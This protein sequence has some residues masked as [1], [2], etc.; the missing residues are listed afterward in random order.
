MYKLFSIRLLAFILL[1]VAMA[2]HG[3]LSARKL[4]QASS[5]K[6]HSA[7]N[8][9][10]SSV[11]THPDPQNYRNHSAPGI[12]KQTSKRSLRSVETEA[13]R[14]S[15]HTLAYHVESQIGHQASCPFEWLENYEAR[16]IPRRIVEQV[17]RSCRSCG[18]SRQCVQLKVRTEVFFGDTGEYGHQFVRAGCA[19]MPYE[20][21]STA[22]PFDI[23][24]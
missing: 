3:D 14:R 5:T 6:E 24:V 19:C 2:A 16:R 10:L 9:V 12:M 8:P 15:C 23:E 22:N 21:G 13:S 20:V 11:E 18:Y 1:S 4:N 17:C 7:S